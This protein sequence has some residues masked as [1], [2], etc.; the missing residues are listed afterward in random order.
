MHLCKVRVIS[1]VYLSQFNS[2]HPLKIKILNT[3]LPSN[4]L[5]TYTSQINQLNLTWQVC[6]NIIL[7]CRADHRTIKSIKAK[8]LVPY[9][10]ANEEVLWEV[11]CNKKEICNDKKLYRF[12]IHDDRKI[13]EDARP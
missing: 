10:S 11:L 2:S 13:K 5:M 12:L 7:N 9:N 4:V 3:H 8:I 6:D 1:E